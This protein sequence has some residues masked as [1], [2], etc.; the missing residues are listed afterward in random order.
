MWRQPFVSNFCRRLPN[1]WLL[2]TV[3]PSGLSGYKHLGMT[4]FMGWLNK[5]FLQSLCRGSVRATPTKAAE[6]GLSKPQSLDGS[7]RIL[8]TRGRPR[9]PTG[10]KVHLSLCLAQAR[11]CW[12]LCGSNCK[13]WTLPT[14]YWMRSWAAKSMCAPWF[15]VQPRCRTTG[16]CK[17]ISFNFYSQ[18]CTFTFKGGKKITEPKE[19]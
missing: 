9:V 17:W 18:Y 19:R 13:L 7:G 6:T 15:C 16:T 8:P 2:W 10:M 3:R 5:S 14:G 12:W 4:G 1:F 11:P